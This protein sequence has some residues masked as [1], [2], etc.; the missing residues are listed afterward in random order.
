MSAS[1]LI[2]IAIAML[3]GGCEKSAESVSS[4]SNSEYRVETLFH[5]DGCTAYRFY[6]G[7]TVHYVKCGDDVRTAWREGCGKNCTR[8]VAVQTA[9]FEGEQ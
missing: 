4:P 5:H 8:P 6:D 1:R 7:R 2:V 3:L 9:M